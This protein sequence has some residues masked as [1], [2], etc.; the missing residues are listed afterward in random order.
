MHAVD[1]KVAPRYGLKILRSIKKYTGL[2]QRRASHSWMKWFA[3]L[4]SKAERQRTISW[5][6]MIVKIVGRK[7]LWQR[8]VQFSL[9]TLL[10]VDF[11]L[12]YFFIHT[13]V[14]SPRTFFVW[15]HFFIV[16][17][18]SNTQVLADDYHDYVSLL[19]MLWNMMTRYM[20]VSTNVFPWFQLR[21]LNL[22]GYAVLRSEN[23][24]VSWPILQVRVVSK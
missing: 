24:S 5:I 12:F 23:K 7:E 10:N 19:R 9:N 17:S 18:T 16:R 11:L 20:V 2:R 4:E 1:I 15:S 3:V 6:E 8:H 22:P 13:T 21:Y 14:P